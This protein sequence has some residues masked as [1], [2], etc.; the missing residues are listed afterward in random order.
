MTAR[1]SVREMVLVLVLGT[2][3]I[4]AERVEGLAV[5]L[6]TIDRVALYS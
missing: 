4:T 2:V 3:S 6:L 5:A 1:R